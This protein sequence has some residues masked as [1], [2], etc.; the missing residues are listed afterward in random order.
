MPIWSVD[1]SSV[2]KILHDITILLQELTHYLAA[3]LEVQ[4]QKSMYYYY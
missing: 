4:K 3:I 1:H 2:R